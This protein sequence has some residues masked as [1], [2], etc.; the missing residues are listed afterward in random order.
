M[1]V[2]LPTS[3]CLYMYLYALVCGKPNRLLLLCWWVLPCLLL[4][5]SHLSVLSGY[6][7]LYPEDW[8][9]LGEKPSIY[10]ISILLRCV[11]IDSLHGLG[12]KG[13]IRG[14]LVCS[15]VSMR[16]ARLWHL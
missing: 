12:W 15:W 4:L 13:P 11:I 14:L 2:G 9:S 7:A 6:L 1:K 3:I 8:E 10:L 16:G 5:V